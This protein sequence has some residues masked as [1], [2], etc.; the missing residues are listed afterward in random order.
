[1]APPPRRA[2][3]R[4]R[5]PNEWQSLIDELTTIGNAEG[6]LSFRAGGRFNDQ[7]RHTRARQIGMQLNM[8]GGS[9]LMRRIYESVDCTNT[10]QL[11]AAWDEIGDWRY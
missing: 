11:A 6:F 2:S 3:T 7:C 1:M 10:R 5:V 4:S 9:A 8:R